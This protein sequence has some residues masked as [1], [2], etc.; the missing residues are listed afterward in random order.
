MIDLKLLQKDFDAT[1]ASLK[2]KNVDSELI[3]SLKTLSET[4][5]NTKLEIGRAHV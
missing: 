2:R 3:N 5:K 4:L 1:A